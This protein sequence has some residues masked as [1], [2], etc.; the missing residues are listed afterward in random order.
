MTDAA[1]GHLRRV[2]AEGNVGVILHVGAGNGAELET[3][4]AAKPAHIRLLEPNPPAAKALQLAAAN[5]PS[6]TVEASALAGQ[7]GTATLRVFNHA[8]LSSLRAPH[9]LT[10]LFPGLHLVS[11]PEVATV[12]VASLLAG[13]PFAE[14]KRNILILDAPGEE[15]RIVEDLR[16]GHWFKRFDH[17]FMYCGTSELYEGSRTANELRGRL[18]AEGFDVEATLRDDP[19]RPCLI[20]RLD[21]TALKVIE[22]ERA[23]AEARSAQD[24]LE[25]KLK[26][27]A[28]AAETAIREKNA[29]EARLK[30]QS[31]L[32]E[33]QLKEQFAIAEARHKE[34]AAAAEAKLMAQQAAAELKLAE[35]AAAADTKLTAQSAA[36]D[37]QLQEKVALAEARLK[38]IEAAGAEKDQQLKSLR[39]ERDKA[40]ADL[41]LALRMQ[42]LQQLDLDDLRV[43]Y[44]QAETARAEHELLLRRLTPRLQEAAQ[45]LKTLQLEDG[46]HAELPNAGISNKPLE[47]G[48]P[49]EAFG[50]DKPSDAA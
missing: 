46:R 35:Q 44:Q 17:V 10:R 13:L 28:A 42:T 22:L 31:A 21:R 12:S 39:A 1:L 8:S 3:Y 43:R 36:T 24:E 30:E 15:G 29:A 19:D 47:S 16:A 20:L 49:K 33:A 38:E 25:A 45:H 23:L 2:A 7:D 27:Q 14:G 11:E 37:A 9:E 6:V 5:A 34:Q 26:A 32:A 4:L 48:H 50:R 18:E 41:S 40:V